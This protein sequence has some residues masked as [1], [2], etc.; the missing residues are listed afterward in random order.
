VARVQHAGLTGAE[1]CHQSAYVQATDP[2]AVGALKAWI[3]T[4][5]TPATH[6][7]RNAAND[8]WI[9]VGVAATTAAS[10]T[11]AGIAEIATQTE[12]DAG[13]DDTRIVTPKKLAAFSGLGGGGGAGPHSLAEHTNVSATLP[14]PGD[15]YRYA[16][17]TVTVTQTEDF[18][19]ETYTWA[20][21]GS[22]ER[23]TDQAHGGTTALRSAVITHGGS[24]ESTMTVTVPSGSTDVILSL[25]YRISS[26]L[27]YDYFR[28]LVGG[29]EVISGSGEVGWTQYSQPLPDGG[30][31][32]TLTFRYEKDS[33]ESAGA[34]AAWVD[35][36]SVSYAGLR[37]PAEWEPVALGH[38]LLSSL[39]TDVAGGQAPAG[40]MALVRDAA[41]G[42]WKGKH[43]PQWSVQEGA[44]SYFPAWSDGG[45][46][47]FS[48]AVSSATP[49]NIGTT[50][51]RLILFRLPVTLSLE[52]FYWLGTES[53]SNSS[54]F[55][56][57]IYEQDTGNRIWSAGPVGLQ[58]YWLGSSS[59]LPVVLRPARAYWLAVTANSTAT[60]AGI[61]TGPS[62][63]L[64]FYQPPG[65]V[66]LGD[67]L[68]AGF[69]V[70]LQM[71]LATASTLPETLP[72][73]AG[74][75]GWTGGVPLVL[76]KGTAS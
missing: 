55:H 35:D 67:K 33:S 12:T 70:Q 22:W 23:S 5:T 20:P 38:N 30:G 64:N 48:A 69:P 60:T 76:L 2:G 17:S 14:S 26:E 15:I 61:R 29:Q 45:P 21:S 59:N 40:G 54:G 13:T 28:L 19:D 74:P 24:T 75:S 10:E 7:V 58:T 62:P 73:L 44:N 43:L 6:R 41:S 31:S 57:A 63:V 37:D 39:H 53:L 18:E 51:A 32:Y 16:V 52:T 66:P 50:T 8:G 36:I 1:A 3:D 11:A 25:W 42:K 68:S 72:A 71:A 49:A 65:N 27:D 56:F 47:V 34:D 4:S 46:S 9:R